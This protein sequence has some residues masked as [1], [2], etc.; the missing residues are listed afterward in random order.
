MRAITSKQVNFSN[1]SRKFSLDVLV[2]LITQVILRLRSFILLP[3]IARTLGASQY[4]AWAQIIVTV[5]LL[6]PIM[7]L[8]LE[9]ACIRYLSSKKGKDVNESFF[10]MLFLILGVI[11]VTLGSGFF[12]RPQIAVFL[13]GDRA[14]TSYAEMLLILLAVRVTFSFL[15]NYYRAFNQIFRYSTVELIATFASIAVAVFFVLSGDGLFGVLL[16]FIVVEALM[17]ILVLMDIIRQIGLPHIGSRSNLVF[18]LHYSLPL[19]PNALLFWVINLSDRFFIAHMLGLS[20]VGIYSASYSLGQL[21]TFFLTPISFV[22]FPLVS[23][24]WGEG[25]QSEV[26]NYMQNSLRYYLLLSVPSVFGIYQLAP[27]VLRGLATQEFVTSRLLVLYVVL[28]FF[29]IGIYQIYLYVIH[30]REKTR[31][32]PFVFLVVALLNVGLN[33]ALIPRIGIMGAAFSTFIAFLVQMIII[34]VYA[35]K[36]FRVHFDVAFFGKTLAASS[37]MLLFLKKLPLHSISGLLVAVSL[38][39][40]IYFTAMVIM[41]G[42]GRKEWRLLIMAF[43]SKEV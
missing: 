27:F 3:L 13:F 40:A 4:G 41:R 38:G 14:Q 25:K 8:R 24:L 28:G 18:Y 10:A 21:A 2:R 5:S 29:C 20:Q 35:S 1:R 12:F 31:Y 6:A 7:T 39:A 34:V 16:S 32:L 22:L 11:T 30:L 15:R 26:R 42:L 36:L 33:F 43:K 23:K 9:T 37:L 17:A 19:I